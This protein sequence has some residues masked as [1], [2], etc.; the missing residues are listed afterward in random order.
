MEDHED[1]AAEILP[2]WEKRSNITT[3]RAAS[4]R[5]NRYIETVI[6]VP[7]TPSGALKA[8]LIKLEANLQYPS[9]IKF[10]E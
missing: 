3:K 7:H 6:V 1:D 2:P 4:Q 10:V 8:K 5:D 9:R